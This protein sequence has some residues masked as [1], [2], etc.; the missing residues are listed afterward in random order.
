MEKFK[1]EQMLNGW[2][3][4]NFN[5]SVL[6]TNDVEVAIKTYVAGSKEK[7]HFH[8]IAT[9]I[10]VI[11]EGKVIMNEI[12]YQTGDIIKILPMECTDFIAIENTKTLVV[13]IPGANNDK[14]FK[15]D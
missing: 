4:G 8:K 6:L 2:I 7:S 12:E 13:K 3:I 1:L 11:I 5:P 10:T 9:E 14:Y 15:Y